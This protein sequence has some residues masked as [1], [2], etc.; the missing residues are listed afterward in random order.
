MSSSDTYREPISQEKPSRCQES[1]G[2]LLRKTVYCR[3]EAQR[4]MVIQPETQDT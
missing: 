4:Q 3:L 2:V 1:T